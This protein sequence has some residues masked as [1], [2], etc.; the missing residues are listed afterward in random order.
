MDKLS[1]AGRVA[2][3]VKLLVDNPNRLFTLSELSEQFFAAKS[4]LSEDIA[5]IRGAF[6]KLELGRIESFAGVAGGVRYMPMRSQ[7]YLRCLMEDLCSR[8]SDP[9][10]LVGNGFLFLNDILNDPQL[11]F[12]LAEAIAGKFVAAGI[13]SVVTVEARGIPLALSVARHLNCQLVIARREIIFSEDGS[14]TPVTRQESYVAEGAMLSVSFV[15]GSHRGVQ[16]M[17][18]P[19]RSLARGSK[20]LIVDDFLRAG[21]TIRGLGELLKEFEASIVGTVVLVETIKPTPKLIDDY[22]SIVRLGETEGVTCILPGN[23]SEKR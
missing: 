17:S 23:I 4:S 1:K 21:G 10:R 20:V 22:I 7:R 13:D 18:I 15:S 11:L 12:R 19:R 6:E 14:P 8:L 16:T 9:A 2:A 5:V 3:I